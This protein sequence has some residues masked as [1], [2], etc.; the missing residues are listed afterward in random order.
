LLITLEDR[1]GPGVLAKPLVEA[2]GHVPEAPAGVLMKAAKGLLVRR[3]KVH[4]PHDLVE[5]RLSHGGPKVSKFQAQVGASSPVS[6]F[7][8]HQLRNAQNLRIKLHICLEFHRHSRCNNT[9]KPFTWQ[10]P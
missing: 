9:R 1:P 4:V 6:H 7:L 2:I 10:A 8:Q 5:E 3:P